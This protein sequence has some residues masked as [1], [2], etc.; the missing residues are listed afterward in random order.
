[1]VSRADANGGFFKPF[2]KVRLELL[3]LNEE[4]D[5]GKSKL[6]IDGT[7]YELPMVKGGE[8]GID[9]TTLRASTKAITLDNGFANTGSCQSA[10]TF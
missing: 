1:M 2:E 9:I 10:I 6:N 7:E 8:T 4:A 5:V 3:A